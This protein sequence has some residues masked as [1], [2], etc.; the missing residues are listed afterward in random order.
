M[1][2]GESRHAWEHRGL[3]FHLVGPHLVGPSRAFALNDSFMLT[4]PFFDRLDSRIVFQRLHCIACL[5][6]L[7][8]SHTLVNAEMAMLPMIG[9]S[10]RA[11]KMRP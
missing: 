9:T 11:T 3:F 4:L 10:I 5:Y 8:V 2:N 7:P 1:L 6:R